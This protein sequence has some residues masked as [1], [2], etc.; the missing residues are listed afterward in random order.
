CANGRPTEPIVVA[1]FDDLRASANESV[2]PL[3]QNGYADAQLY[4][5]TE[6]SVRGIPAFFLILGEPVAY[7][8]PPKP[9]VPTIYLKSA[10][11]AAFAT[12]LASIIATLLGFAL[13]S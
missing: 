7:G 3:K 5:P 11:M 9:Q 13:F 10:W 4:D 1:R 2:Q 6:T 8:L 12:A